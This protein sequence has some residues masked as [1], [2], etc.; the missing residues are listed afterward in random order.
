MKNYD[1]K[2]NPFVGAG[3]LGVT[4]PVAV[5]VIG[6]ITTLV[7]GLVSLFLFPFYYSGRLDENA[8]GNITAIVGAVMQVSAIVLLT[9]ILSVFAGMK[10]YHIL[11]SA[12]ISTSLFFL[13]ERFIPDVRWVSFPEVH[14]IFPALFKRY[15]INYGSLSKAEFVDRNI[16][17]ITTL[18]LSAACLLI[19]LTT[20]AIH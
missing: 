15:G 19:V 10:I 11:L 16:Y 18:L 20:W 7:W 4:V 12:A 13:V 8:F 1:S 5:Y 2:F 14:I 3:I 17:L 6:F 9:L